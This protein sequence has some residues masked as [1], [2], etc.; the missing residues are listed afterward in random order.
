MVAVSLLL[1]I[2][3]W[4]SGIAGRRGTRTAK[5]VGSVAFAPVDVVEI[6]PEPEIKIEAEPVVIAAPVTLKHDNSTQR[7]VLIALI[8]VLVTMALA[9]LVLQ[10]RENNRR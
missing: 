10:P 7:A 3:V 4:F 8:I 5:V 2:A 1:F 9:V 6:T